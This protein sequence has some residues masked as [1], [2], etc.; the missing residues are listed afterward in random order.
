MHT[1]HI[2]FFV[3]TESSFY[4]DFEDEN[5][6]TC[7]ILDKMYEHFKLPIVCD[8]ISE[9]TGN[10]N[11]NDKLSQKS[12]DYRL[13]EKYHTIN[14]FISGI[15]F[16]EIKDSNNKA[17]LVIVCRVCQLGYYTDEYNVYPNQLEGFDVVYKEE[18]TP[19]VRM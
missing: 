5:S 12:I 15:Y 6:E 16:E 9:T 2:V 17:K 19:V 10:D 7:Q 11:L 1:N 18:R 14:T 8:I 3:K 13:F 4:Q